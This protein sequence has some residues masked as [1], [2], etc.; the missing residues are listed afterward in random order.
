MQAELVGNFLESD[1][2]GYLVTSFRNISKS[3]NS[4]WLRIIFSDTLKYQES[5]GESLRSVAALYIEILKE[6]GR[7]MKGRIS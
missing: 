5:D 6:E 1:V 7:F 2:N 3:L 4:F